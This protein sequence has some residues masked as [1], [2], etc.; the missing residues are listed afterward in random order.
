MLERTCTSLYWR[1]WV[2]ALIVMALLSAP[3]L[4]LQQGTAKPAPALSQAE[5]EASARVKVET[6]REVTT[7][8]S[9]DAME[10]RGTAQPGGDKAAQYL[11]AQFQ[12]LGLK[13]L[14]DNAT[15][16]Q[17]IKF[18][19]QAV[20]PET[21][22]K[23]GDTALKMRDDFA[24]APPFSSD[25]DVSSSLVFVGYGVTSVALKRDDLKDLDLQGK[26]AVILSGRPKTA[27]PQLWA[28]AANQQTIGINLIRRG[29]AGLMVLN[30]GSPDQP[31]SL[32][33]D[34][35]TRRQVSIDAGQEM[36][37]N[38]PPIMLVCDAGAEKI[39]AGSGMTYAQVKARAESGDFV[40][41]DL[42]KPA[43]V[44]VRIKRER[45]TGSNVVGVL[46]GA[47]AQLKSEAVVY[48]AHYD[49]FGIT[50]DGRIYHGAAD[51]ALGV[52]ELLSVAEA[53]AKAP[54]RPRRSVI[55]LA[56]TGEEY[57][58]LG[59]EYW[60]GHPTWPIEKVA[61]DINYDGIGTEVYGPVKRVVGF[62]MEYSDLGPA[63][64][65]VVNASGATIAPDPMP[66]EKVFYRSDHYAFVKKGVP[67][68]MLLGGPEGDVKPWIE[69]AK[70]WMDTDYHQPSDV[71]RPDWNWEGA[72]TIA[73]IGLLVGM[74]VANADVAPKWLPGAPFTRS[75][76]SSGASNSPE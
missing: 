55:F 27:D 70:K 75:G 44:I 50:P 4:A 23:V 32:I 39:F 66:E 21:S 51:N 49:A 52:G 11:A 10:G 73:V 28:R 67:A 63:L 36:S 6:L 14:G 35:L 25:V 15:Y 71:I 18:K 62:G 72:R 57:G 37:F 54:Q 26:I 61:A 65:S 47:D 1:A 24:L 74:R 30:A 13:P 5:K 12:K 41:Q 76:S 40:S 22:I 68:L 58:L 20:L 59:S 9:A 56:V 69:R 34:Y 46:E 45:G 3:A 31:Y 60:A 29:V 48:T 2:A 7:A 8:L 17:A 42:K 33:A 19:S 64:E 38:I 53:Y 16:L 43:T